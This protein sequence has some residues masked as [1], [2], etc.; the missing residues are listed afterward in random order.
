V[1]ET[2]GELGTELS[3][4]VEPTPFPAGDEPAST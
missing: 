1:T 3:R 2:V 4:S